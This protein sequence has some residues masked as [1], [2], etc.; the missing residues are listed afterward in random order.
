MGVVTVTLPS[1]GIPTV[2]A[3]GLVEFGDRDKTSKLVT[4]EGIPVTAAKPVETDLVR[5]REIGGIGDTVTV[6]V[7][8]DGIWVTGDDN[9]NPVPARV[10]AVR[11]MVVS[12]TDDRLEFAKVETGTVGYDIP[13]GVE[14]E[15]TRM[16]VGTNVTFLD[17]L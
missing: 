14:V 9:G 7:I 16:T 10:E 17:V 5:F 3:T 11:R 2:G 8:F 4:L 1:V 12:D 15:L 6:N 13:S